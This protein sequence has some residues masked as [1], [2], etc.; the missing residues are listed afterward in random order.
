MKGQNRCIECG[1]KKSRSR[2]R[3]VYGSDGY[4]IGWVCT[5]CLLAIGANGGDRK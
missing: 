2:L 3:G 5:L 1:K 4:R